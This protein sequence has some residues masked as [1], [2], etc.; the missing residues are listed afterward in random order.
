MGLVNFL[1]ANQFLQG[2]KNGFSEFARLVADGVNLILLF[3][4]YFLGVGA[5]SLAAKVFG[6]HFL[7]LKPG[8][9]VQTSYWQDIH[10]EQFTDKDNFYRMF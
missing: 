6:K 3:L 7:D 1:L 5:T 10:Q 9:K 8:R 4:V 2:F